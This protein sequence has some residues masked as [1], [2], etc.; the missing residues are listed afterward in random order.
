MASHNDLGWKGEEM[1]RDHLKKKGFV[2][3]EKNWRFQRA[4]IDI[5]DQKG[6][7]LSVVEVKT[8]S[9]SYF[10]EPGEFIHRKKIKSLTRAIDHYIQQEEL[11][12]EVRFDVIGIVINQS[13]ISIV[14]WE[15]AFY[16]F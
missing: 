4:E 3:R 6:N 11:D 5:I 14:H 2:I 8:R 10:G 12:V 16:H 7:L 1:A 9:S 13:N 15:D